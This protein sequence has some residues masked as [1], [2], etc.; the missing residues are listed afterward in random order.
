MRKLVWRSWPALGLLLL[1]ACVTDIAPSVKYNPP[2]TEALRNFAHFDL[3]PLQ[4]SSDAQAE[5]DALAKIDTNLHDRISAVTKAWDREDPNGRT[6]KIQPYV[7]ELKFVDGGTRFFAGAFAGSSAVVMQLR[8]IDA[9][10]KAV[11][12]QPEFFQ[13]AAAMGGAWSIGGTDNSMLERIAGVAQEYL[14]RNYDDA[15]GGPTGADPE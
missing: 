11:V 3:M 12:A 5:K 13:R 9:A 15:V 4:A 10:T 2:P 7:S 6:L 14:R 1:C 8:L